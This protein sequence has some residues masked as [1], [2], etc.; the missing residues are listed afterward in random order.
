D[1]PVSAL[2]VSVQAQ[3]LNLLKDLQEELGLT[4]LF[5]SHNLAVVDYVAD[6]IA[7]MCAGRIVETAP[8]ETLFRNPMHPYT[9]ALL[10]AVPKADPG[11]KLDLTALMEGKA[12]VPSAWPA[13]FTLD[14][15]GV[16]DMID[17]GGGHFVRAKAGTQLPRE[18]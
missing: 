5:I 14:D 15:G 18:M 3:V 6:R 10:A 16:A 4:Y 17:A 11:A 7:V 12:S 9:Q 1:E 8:R 2:D 13:P